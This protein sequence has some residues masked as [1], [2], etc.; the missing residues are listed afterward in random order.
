[1]GV[2]KFKNRVLGL[3]WFRCPFWLLV[4]WLPPTPKG[5]SSLRISWSG[6]PLRA[7]Q[8]ITPLE[9]FKVRWG[10]TLIL[11]SE[12]PSLVKF[13]SVF[14]W[15]LV[16][17][18]TKMSPDLSLLTP[19]GVPT[20]AFIDFSIRKGEAAWRARPSASGSEDI[21]RNLGH[22]DCWLSAEKGSIRA[23]KGGNCRERSDGGLWKVVG[24][25]GG[26]PCLARFTPDG[27]GYSI[28]ADNES[29]CKKKKGKERKTKLRIRTILENDT[30]Q[31]T[32]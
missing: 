13:S 8:L 11:I 9:E 2:L 16:E 10:E 21:T 12:L 18:S 27:P 20:R 23:G 25:V 29:N 14:D 24:E 1:M 17:N 5:L 3:V 6:I 15:F 22:E 32:T 26:E 28:R 31:K 30:N 19:W 4:A 7:G